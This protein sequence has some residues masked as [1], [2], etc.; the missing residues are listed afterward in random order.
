MNNQLEPPREFWRG[1]L[2]AAKRPFT[3]NERKLFLVL[4]QAEVLSDAERDKHYAEI[5][6]EQ[7][8]V[9]NLI[10]NQ[11]FE[12]GVE[13]TS[14][15]RC[16][17]SVLAD[18]FPVGM[19]WSYTINFIWVLEGKP[20]TMPMLYRFFRFTTPT[21]LGLSSCYREWRQYINIHND[22]PRPSDRWK[23]VSYP[24]IAN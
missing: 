23:L 17:C 1:F 5:I 12:L 14:Q 3:P 6:R 9:H 13:T 20:V 24:F 7:N 16:F 15:V 4:N 8:P 19:M 21:F 2:D 18:N 10:C 11:L 22:W